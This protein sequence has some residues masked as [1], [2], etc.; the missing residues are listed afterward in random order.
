MKSAA[1]SVSFVPT[2]TTLPNF[3]IIGA[4]KSGSTTLY[5]HLRD[6]PRVFMTSYKEPEFFVAEK[7][8]SRGVDWYSRLF[9]G[10]GDALAVGE[11][12]TSYT[13]AGEFDGVPARIRS[14]I[15][16]ARLIYI[17]RDPVAR[18]QS[19]Y[20]HLV[21]TGHESRPIDEAVLT[22]PKYLGPSLYA[23]NLQLYLEHFP[24]EQLHIVF[25]DDL[26]D[27]PVGTVSR[28]TRFLDLPPQP[29]FRPAA[30]ED[31][32]TSERFA[33]RRAK[34]WVRKFPSV[35][36]AFQQLPAPVRGGLRRVAT[37]KSVPERPRLSAE[38]ELHLRERLAPDLAE[39]RRLLGDDM[40]PWGIPSR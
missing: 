21:L 2:S 1:A 27:D 11:A 6:H 38:A 9:A 28:V 18:I 16:E 19:M 7:T 36:I 20:E 25:T 39:L 10:A 40:V 3:L 34:T 4:M 13:K 26:R 8:W 37:R 32:K 33:D 15:P 5:N 12:S 14:L 30:R 22:D 24:R 31:L 29:G 23:R 17:L 35:H